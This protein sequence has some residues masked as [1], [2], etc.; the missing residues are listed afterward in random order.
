[1][2]IMNAG[3]LNGNKNHN[4]WYIIIRYPF[5]LLKLNLITSPKTLLNKIQN[6]IAE[7]V[8]VFITSRFLYSFRNIIVQMGF[9]I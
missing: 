3:A 7:R 4:W 1:M 9:H 5:E 8:K 2:N 6:I